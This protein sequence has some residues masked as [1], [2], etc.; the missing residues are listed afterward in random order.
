MKRLR[1]MKVRKL[2]FEVFFG[3]QKGFVY[4]ILPI[5]R[6]ELSSEQIRFKKLRAKQI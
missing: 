3:D 5:E 6:D 4:K 2:Y 1:G